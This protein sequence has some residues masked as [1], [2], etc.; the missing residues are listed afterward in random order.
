MTYENLGKC[1]GGERLITG[2]RDMVDRGSYQKYRLSADADVT[3]PAGG[4]H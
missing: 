4:L 3:Q 1:G 2:P